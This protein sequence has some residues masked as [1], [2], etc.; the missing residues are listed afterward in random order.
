MSGAA[1][2]GAWARA[3]AGA[4][5]TSTD[6]ITPTAPNARPKLKVSRREVM[7]ENASRLYE[8]RVDVIQITGLYK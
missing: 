5:P 3:G 1:A 6:R 7:S 2:A 8:W 4:A